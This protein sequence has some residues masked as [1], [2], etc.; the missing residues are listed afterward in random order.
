MKIRSV[1]TRVAVAEMTVAVSRLNRETTIVAPRIAESR[2]MAATDSCGA[3]SMCIT[4]VSNHAPDRAAALA[5][6]HA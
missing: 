6:I 5:P 1:C 4:S 2:G 3:I